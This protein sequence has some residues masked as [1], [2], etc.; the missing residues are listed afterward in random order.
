M[1]SPCKPRFCPRAL[2]AA[3][4]LAAAALLGSPDKADAQYG[5]AN[6]YVCQCQGF[7]CV[8]A[9]TAGV[10]DGAP[11]YCNT[12]WGA[13]GGYSIDLS[14]V[15]RLPE[16]MPDPQS[17]DPARPPPPRADPAEVDVG[18]TDCYRGLGNCAGSFQAALSLGRVSGAPGERSGATSTNRSRSSS[19]FADD[20]Y[21]LIEEATDDFR[22]L[23]A[24]FDRVMTSGTR[25]YNVY[26]IPASFDRCSL[27]RRDRGGSSIVCR[28]D[29]Q[30]YRGALRQ[31][32]EV[33][34]D[35][36]DESR[37]ESEWTVN[38]VEVVLEDDDGEEVILRIRS[39]R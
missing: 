6:T 3:T 16:G 39:P 23:D 17:P 24:E 26:D 29:R 36:Y 14:G 20:L 13:V 18:D 32:T 5:A 31:V 25:I 22:G 30:S 2:L 38:R 10:P 1:S 34:G 27:Y 4:A 9:W 21:F 15:D 28:G 35:P 37:Y 33:L 19:R 12:M 11:C 7:W 8:F